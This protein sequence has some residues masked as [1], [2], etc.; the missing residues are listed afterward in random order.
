MF[1]TAKYDIVV[2][3]SEEMNEENKTMS[4]TRNGLKVSLKD[5]KKCE[6]SNEENRELKDR[7][8]KIKEDYTKIKIDHGNLLVA[9]ELFES[10][11]EGEGG[12]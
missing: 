7:F 4:S 2:Q 10:R 5:A 1:L 8:V 12:E 9:Y 6:K 11:L 3:A